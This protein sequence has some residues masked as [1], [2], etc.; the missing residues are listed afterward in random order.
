MSW[1]GCRGIAGIAE[2]DPQQDTLLWSIPAIF[3]IQLIVG[4][5]NKPC[6]KPA[7]HQVERL[8]EAVLDGAVKTTFDIPRLGT[9][10]M[11]AGSVSSWSN[12]TSANSIPT[13]DLDDDCLVQV[14]HP[15]TILLSVVPTES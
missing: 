8:V 7:F 2:I 4:D 14:R 10:M 13:M 5:G 11:A 3:K 15:L 6:F 12:K 1:I 9:Q